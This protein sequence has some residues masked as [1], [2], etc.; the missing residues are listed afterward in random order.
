MFLQK[1]KKRVKFIYCSSKILGFV[2]FE[3]DVNSRQQSIHV[4]WLTSDRTNTQDHKYFLQHL[5]FGHNQLF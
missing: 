5:L 4:H 3:A 2:P 1:K